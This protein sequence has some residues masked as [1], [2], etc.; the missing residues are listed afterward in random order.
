MQVG[1]ID[2]IG[3]L[4]SLAEAEGQEGNSFIFSAA[5]IAIIRIV[6]TDAEDLFVKIYPITILPFKI[7]F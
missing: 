2:L 3:N 1:I 4:S 7:S 5:V 6:S